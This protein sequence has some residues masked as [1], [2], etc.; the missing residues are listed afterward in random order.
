MGIS[1]QI[2]LEWQLAKLQCDHRATRVIPDGS[3]PTEMKFYRGVS[4]SIELKRRV[5][6]VV[7]F[8]EDC[9]E[10]RSIFSFLTGGDCSMLWGSTGRVFICTSHGLTPSDEIIGE[11]IESQTWI[12]E[13]DWEEIDKSEFLQA[14]G[15]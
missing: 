12:T 10:K 9:G 1:A 14:G 5:K 15:T 2:V 6:N 13:G 8:T 7:G 4:Y 11:S 3:D